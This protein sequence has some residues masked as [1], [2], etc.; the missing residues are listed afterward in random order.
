MMAALT[1]LRAVHSIPSLQPRE[2]TLGLPQNRG[3]A[4]SPGIG[5][6]RPAE[7]RVRQAHADARD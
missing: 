4:S 6:P 3:E 7:A 2:R 5:H 1:Q